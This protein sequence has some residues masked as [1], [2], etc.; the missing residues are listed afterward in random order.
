M[1]YEQVILK[2]GL[3]YISEATQTTEKGLVPMT[4]QYPL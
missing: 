2:M 4:W 1:T 3:D